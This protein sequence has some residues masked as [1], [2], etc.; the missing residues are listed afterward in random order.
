MTTK[1]T[2]NASRRWR[3]TR[4][5]R[6]LLTL[7]TILLGVVAATDQ[8]VGIVVQAPVAAFW[9]AVGTLA[10]GFPLLLGM[11]RLYA[12][13]GRRIPV[14]LLPAVAVL[15]AA[16]VAGAG[17]SY[18][19]LASTGG[20]RQAQT[21]ARGGHDQASTPQATPTGPGAALPL[22][23]EITDNHQGTPVFKDPQ[24]HQIDSGQQKIQFGAQVQVSCWTE[25]LAGMATV[26][27]LYRL[28]TAPWVGYY[29]PADTFA[30]GDVVGEPGGTAID[31]AVPHCPTS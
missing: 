11:V 24:G 6:R 20:L 14:P 10:V 31:P 17:M 3:P 9:I 30:N 1:G 5:D 27:K 23:T 13:R 7:A 12:N 26:S 4:S 22:H 29:A 16:I 25:S 8:L 19:V 28:E 18:V 15:A 2:G 21:S